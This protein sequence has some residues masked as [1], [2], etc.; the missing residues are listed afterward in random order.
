MFVVI[1]AFII[2]VV[3]FVFKKKDNKHTK[4]ICVFK[5]SRSNIIMTKLEGVIFSNKNEIS[6]WL[7]VTK[8]KLKMKVVNYKCDKYKIRTKPKIV[9][10]KSGFVCEFEV[11]ITPYCTM[12][13]SDEIMI[14][15]L[16]L[17]YGKGI[18]EDCY[19]F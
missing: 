14:V 9:T 16:D 8:Y 4:N 18:H 13:L 11:F 12:D 5:M 6:F 1:I 17:H 19:F 10:L 3:L 7:K 2:I 15:S